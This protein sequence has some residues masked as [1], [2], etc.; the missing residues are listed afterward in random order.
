MGCRK[1]SFKREVYSS[2]IL[3]QETRKTSN[4]QPNI[5]PKTTEKKEQ[6]N[7]KIHRRKEI[8]KIQA[9]LQ[10]R[11]FEDIS[12]TNKPLDKLIR[13]K[14]SKDKNYQYQ[15]ETDVST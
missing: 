12:K 6:K 5:T 9:E 3:P 2:T 1:S 11:V 15:T 8:I 13:K 10:S 4:T 14:K 7:P